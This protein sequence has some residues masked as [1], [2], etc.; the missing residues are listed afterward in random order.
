M[1]CDPDS[2]RLLKSVGADQPG[3]NL[4]G[5]HHHR[6]RI[7][8]GI[9]NPRDRIGGAGTAG[10]QHHARLT[11]RAGIALRRMRRAGLVADEDVTQAPPVLGIGEQF[12]VDRQHRAAGIAEHEFDILRREAIDQYLRTIA[13]GSHKSLHRFCAWWR[14]ADR[15]AQIGPTRGL[16]A[17]R[18]N[19][20]M[21]FE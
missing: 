20:A 6:D 18:T 5:D 13:L 14:D 16:R 15:Q 17:G 2:V 11:G 7:H 1:P 9:G 12:V 4:A 10:N 8:P 19:G 21:E 3:G